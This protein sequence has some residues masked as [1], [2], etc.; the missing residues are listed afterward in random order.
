M[1]RRARNEQGSALVVALL[2]LLLLTALGLALVLTTTTETVIANNQRLG[3]EAANAADAALERAMQDLLA[4]PDWNRALGGTDQSSFTDGSPGPRTLPDGTTIDLTEIA[5]MASCGHIAACSSGEIA[6]NT[7]NRVWGANNPVWQ[8]YASGPVS[9]LLPA[10][11][12]SS[13]IYVVVLVADD[14]SETDGNPLAD[15]TSGANPGTGVISLRAEAYGPNG[16]HRVIEA[17][18][19]RTDSSQLE[20]GYTGQRGQDEQNRRARKSAVQTPG[21]ALTASQLTLS[22]GALH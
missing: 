18:V 22:T 10:G 5:N 17:T 13:P 4:I 16:T 2:S 6:T 3:Q 8:V 14:P 7:S 15:G 1:A 20:R 12:V 21:K 11:T 9:T 19:A